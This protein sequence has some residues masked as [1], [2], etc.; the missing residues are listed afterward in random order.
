MSPAS[1]PGRPVAAASAVIQPTPQHPA[2][3]DPSRA[4]PVSAAQA[5]DHVRPVIEAVVPDRPT[6]PHLVV[7][8]TPPEA[9]GDADGPGAT[10]EPRASVGNAAIVPAAERPA[11]PVDLADGS[12]PARDQA[13]LT[14]AP[15]IAPPQGSPNPADTRPAPAAQPLPAIL[16]PV[17]DH[18]GRPVTAR[19]EVIDAG[20]GSRVRIDLEPADLGRVEVALRLDD[21]GAATAS[22][23]VERPETL[24]LLQRDARVVNEILG[25]A[26]FT[27]E[28]GGLDFSLGDSGGR[29]G[30]SRPAPQ[31][32]WAEARSGSPADAGEPAPSRRRGL[33]DLQV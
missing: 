17:P 10:D 31:P 28:Q 2:V 5:P 13:T 3:V 1:R 33:L 9:G 26:G 22:F 29:E 32:A 21:S 20:D 11:E 24:Q 7:A 15:E 12:A 19:L 23:T 30:G 25:A 4:E 6:R 18:R 16:L 14:A 27:V 8:P